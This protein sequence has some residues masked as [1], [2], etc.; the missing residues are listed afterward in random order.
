MQIADSVV[1][2]VLG[3]GPHGGAEIAW[4][5]RT[6]PDVAAFVLAATTGLSPESRALALRLGSIVCEVFERSGAPARRVRSRAFTLRL[7]ANYDLAERVGVADERFAERYLRGTRALRQPALLRF[8]SEILLAPATP[9]LDPAERGPLFLVLK[10]VVDVLDLA[11]RRPP[12]R[13]AP[14]PGA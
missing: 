6:R 8:L 4:L 1:R 10:T 5:G 2:G 14:A 11:A 7:L 3:G 13:R 12:R 9:V